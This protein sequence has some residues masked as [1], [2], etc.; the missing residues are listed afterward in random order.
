MEQTSDTR[1]EEVRDLLAR[2][3]DRGDR[4]EALALLL[5]VSLR[6]VQGWAAGT[7]SPPS[8]RIGG[9]LERLRT[10]LDGAA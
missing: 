8:T 9:V 3:R 1:R 7:T 4:D 2:A 10:H 5:G 6:T